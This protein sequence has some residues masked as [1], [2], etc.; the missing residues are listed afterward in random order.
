[1]PDTPS[2]LFVPDGVPADTADVVSLIF[3]GTKQ[4][5]LLPDCGNVVLGRK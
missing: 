3:P 2:V 4:F 5:V 1:M